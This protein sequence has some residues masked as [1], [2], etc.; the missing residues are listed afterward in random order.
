MRKLVFAALI[1]VLGF[2][3]GASF[4]QTTPAIKPPP[5]ATAGPAPATATRTDDT[6]R[7]LAIG[8]GA[9]SGMVVLTVMSGNMISTRA[10]ASLGQGALVFIGTVVGGLA[11]NWF[12]TRDYQ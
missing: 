12:Y 5:P 8:L 2:G 3:P 6:S 9:I 4:A 1:A 10:L 11:G 7:V